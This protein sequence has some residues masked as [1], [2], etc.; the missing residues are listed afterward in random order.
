MEQV[1]YSFFK[2]S[3]LGKVFVAST[4][5]GIL[6]IDFMTT[7]KGF[8]KRLSRFFHGE[9]ISD[10]NRNRDIISEI[11]KYLSGKLKHFN[12]KLDLRGTPFQK[13]VWLEL[14]KI[15]YGQTRS[16]KE[17]A[18]AIGKPKG[19]RAVGG[20]NGQNPIPLI[21]PCHRVISSSGDLGG[22][23]HGIKI[24]KRLIELEKI[25]GI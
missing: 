1:Y 2:S 15:P 6:M 21:I 13:R 7:E 25:N 17:I 3:F 4:K 5:K 10:K 9:V 14:R 18:M 11:K 22:Y 24:K 12:C 8:L 19:S 23:S 16:Y 20:A